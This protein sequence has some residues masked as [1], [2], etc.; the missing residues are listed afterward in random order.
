MKRLILGLFAAL[1]CGFA[2]AAPN[3]LNIPG[4]T[5]SQFSSNI[6]PAPTYIDTRVLGAASSETHTVPTGARF[7]LFSAD[8]NFYA[9]VGASAAVPAADVTDGTGSEQNPAA[10]LLPVGTTQITLIA[11]TACKITMAFYN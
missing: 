8:C 1:L 10:W 2:I 6:R 11:A 3:A 4:G 5:N 7:V 9:K